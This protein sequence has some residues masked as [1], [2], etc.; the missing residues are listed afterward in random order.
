M[1]HA[2]IKLYLG[3]TAEGVNL[4]RETGIKVYQKTTHGPGT[5]DQAVD[6]LR[7]PKMCIGCSLTDLSI[8]PWWVIKLTQDD[9]PTLFRISGLNITDEFG[10]KLSYLNICF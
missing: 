5:A 7:T 3:F 4:A 2:L 6:G 10:G 9:K 1:S 8:Q